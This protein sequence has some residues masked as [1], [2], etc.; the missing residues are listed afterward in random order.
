[1]GKYGKI[2]ISDGSGMNLLNIKEKTW[3][4]NIYAPF[5]GKGNKNVC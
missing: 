3:E 2:D 5:F 4:Q 1:M